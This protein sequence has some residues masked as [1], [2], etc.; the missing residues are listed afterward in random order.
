M[1]TVQTGIGLLGLDAQPA[2]QGGT[3]LVW[4][5]NPG[6]GPEGIA[7]YRLY[8][9]D[10]TSGSAGV[11]IGPDPITET[12]YTDSE[13]TAGTHYRLSA[14]NG[15]GEE[16]ELGEVSLGPVRTLLA[17]PLPY[18]SGELHVS[19]SIF[20]PLGATTGT[21]EVGLYDPSGRQVRMLARGSFDGRQQAVIWDGRDAHGSP[22][23]SGIYFLEAKSG[24]Q[25]SH[26]KIAVM[27]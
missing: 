2:P 11:R 4:S 7:G 25:T 14:M 22:V 9:V 27:R 13:G 23:A 24:A 6:V 5:T 8:R 19:F 17:W 15:L 3:L 18:R 26:V 16:L 21:A 1:F 20:G 10:S 12:R